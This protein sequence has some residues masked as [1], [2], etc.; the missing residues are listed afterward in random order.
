M[1]LQYRDFLHEIRARNVYAKYFVKGNIIAGSD[2]SASVR[3]VATRPREVLRSTFRTHVGDNFV[4]ATWRSAHRTQR[5]RLRSNWLDALLAEKAP[6]HVT[7]E[8]S[9]TSSVQIGQRSSSA[10]T[11]ARDR[12]ASCMIEVSERNGENFLKFVNKNIFAV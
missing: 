12:L 4:R 11:S 2:E 7:C 10:S 8:A 6:Q 1:L 3:S 5:R 9:T